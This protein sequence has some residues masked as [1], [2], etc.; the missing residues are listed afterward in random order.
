MTGKIGSISDIVNYISRNIEIQISW[1][2]SNEAGEQRG[3]GGYPPRDKATRN[4]P[5]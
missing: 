5:R 4:R 3:I 1:A 2:L